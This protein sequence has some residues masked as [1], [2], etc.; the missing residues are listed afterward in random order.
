YW[1]DPALV[2]HVARLEAEMKRQAAQT[3]TQTP[4]AGSG[5]EGTWDVSFNNYRGKME[6][7]RT[8]NSWTGRIWLDA[9]QR[10]EQ[11]TNIAFYSTT[12]RIEFTRPLPGATQRY[13][14]TLSGHRLEGTF[15]QEGQSSKYNWWAE[16]KQ[17]A[18]DKPS[19]SSGQISQ[20]VTPPQVVQPPAA[21]PGKTNVLFNNGNTSGVYNAPT[22]PTTF[23]INSPHVITLINNYH[24]NNG[25]G[26][27]PGTIG[28]RTQSGQMYGP[29]QTTGKPGQGGVQNAYWECYPNITIPAGTYTVIDSD[30]ATWAQNS[31][32]QSSGQTRIEGY[33]VSG[34][35][36]QTPVD[37]GSG[38]MPTPTPTTKTGSSVVAEFENRGRDNVHI[39]TVGQDSFGPQNRLTPGQR[40]KVEIRPPS[41]GGYVKFI[42]GRNGQK[43][44]ECKWEYLPD[45][46]TRVPVVTFSEPDRLGCVTGLR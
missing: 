1:N 22:R 11:L 26:A 24:W 27:R 21:P 8:G 7:D 25:K 23:T 29:W 3:A 28:L 20:P 18:T 43:L 4:S 31:G 12:G 2:E 45:S 19:S 16:R 9:G 40:K 10:W 39:V 6:L 15:T 36:T 41:G 34:G 32:S 35:V 33:P 5:A 13:S 17:G 46:P 30:T 38:P 42:A 37:S 14:G 44:A